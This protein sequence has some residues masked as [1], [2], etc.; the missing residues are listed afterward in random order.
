MRCVKCLWRLGIR[1]STLSEGAIVVFLLAVITAVWWVM[2]DP[3]TAAGPAAD[4]AAGGAAR[5][6]P[7]S[8][9]MRSNYPSR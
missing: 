7:R 4:T 2:R 8:S 3:A 6:R 9:E 5:T 1:R